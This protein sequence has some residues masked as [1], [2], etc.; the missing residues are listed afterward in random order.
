MK[1]DIQ[2]DAKNNKMTI[3]VSV[4]AQQKSR[5]P[6]EVFMWK[7]V[8][9][10]LKEYTPPKGYTLGECHLKI[11][12]VDNRRKDKLHRKWIFDLVE[13][14]VN[15]KTDKKVKPPVKSIKKRARS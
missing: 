6:V 7:H 15:Q 1:I 12:K 2:N 11:Q 9:D 10:L 8:L 3:S 13:E 4:D 5:D 14:K